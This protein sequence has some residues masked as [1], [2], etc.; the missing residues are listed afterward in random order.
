MQSTLLSLLCQQLHY[1]KE[2]VMSPGPFD[3]GFTQSRDLHC[4]HSCLQFPHRVIAGLHVAFLWFLRMEM[5]PSCLSSKTVELDGKSYIFSYTVW[6]QGILYTKV[7]MNGVLN[8]F[9]ALFDCTTPGDVIYIRVVVGSFPE[10][11]SV[12]LCS[13]GP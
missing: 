3:L 6:D 10:L 5:L 13:C 7:G 4:T 9:R 1:S 8:I 11:C 2:A 12:H